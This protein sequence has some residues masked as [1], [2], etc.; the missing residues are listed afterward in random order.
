MK[1]KDKVVDKILSSNQIQDYEVFYSPI[2]SWIVFFGILLVIMIPLLLVLIPYII[3]KIPI[4]T[5]FIF[6]L[7]YFSVGYL[8]ISRL[9]HSFAITNKE[10]IIIN[11]HTIFRKLT[12]FKFEE[13]KNIRIASS[14]KLVILSFFGLV[15][16]HYIEINTLSEQHR[17]YCLFLDVDCYDENW[18]EK[19]LD[20][21]NTALHLKKLKVQ[22]ELD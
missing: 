7:T 6:I 8:I 9:N 21:F 12:K 19:N 15:L 22:F 14:K 18:T 2:K 13:I 10:L 11:S 20:D 5:F 1:L 17:F 3:S 16:F 4:N